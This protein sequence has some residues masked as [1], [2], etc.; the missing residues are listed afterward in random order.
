MADLKCGQ[1]EYEAMDE[2]DLRQ[3][4]QKAHQGGSGGGRGPTG[5]DDMSM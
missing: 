2:N 4:Q 1:C 3:H 5:E